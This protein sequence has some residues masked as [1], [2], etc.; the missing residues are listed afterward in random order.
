MRK[1]T[2]KDQTADK[3]PDFLRSPSINDKVDS[4]DVVQAL[5]W[6]LTTCI[7]LYHNSNKWFPCQ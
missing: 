7:S 5:H 6:A 3:L 2:R 4:G 1:C